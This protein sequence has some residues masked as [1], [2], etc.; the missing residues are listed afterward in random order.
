MR[1][2]EVIILQIERN[3]TMTLLNGM[4]AQASDATAEI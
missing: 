4:N 3:D 1:P 2:W